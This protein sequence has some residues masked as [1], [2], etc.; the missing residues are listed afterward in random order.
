MYIASANGW[1]DAVAASGLAAF[2]HV[3]I[4]LVDGDRIPAATADALATLAPTSITVV[5]GRAA[6]PDSVVDAMHATRLGGATRYE[7]SDAVAAAAVAAGADAT[8]LWMATGADWPD[9]LTAGPAA[10]GSGAV[11]RL[12]N[13]VLPQVPG[14]VKELVV[15]GGEAAVRSAT[16]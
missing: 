15:V 1:A 12:V 11:L 3:P 13:G 4:L 8:R 9:A 14:N 16:R 2:T 6:V 7:T 10:A 5:G